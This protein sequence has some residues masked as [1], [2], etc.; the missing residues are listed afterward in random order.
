MM[1]ATAAL[2]AGTVTLVDP[3]QRRRH[4]AARQA[5]GPR[6]TTPTAR[7]WAGCR[8][9][10]A[11]RSR[12]TSSRRRS[13]SGSATTTR[14]SSAMLY[15]TWLKL[16][17]GAPTGIDVAGEV[18]RPRPRPG[19]QAVA[20]DRPRQRRVRAGRGGHPDPARDGVRRDHER[21][22]AHPAARG[23]GHRRRATS[24]PRRRRRS[25]P[26]SCPEQLDLADEPRRRR[27]SVL[28]ATARSC[29]ATRWAARPA[30]P[31]SGI[32]GAGGRGGWKV[33]LFNYSFIGYIARERRV[34]D[35]VVAIRIEEGRPTIARVGQL[36][37]PVLSH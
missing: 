8:S 35:L 24:S 30:R 32:R 17:F 21:R 6:S 28:Q 14:T 29:P 13:R 26:G 15:D 1:T 23:Q 20:P 31:R 16:G 2:E 11:S 37:M 12:A 34:P 3:D 9:R 10:T 22:H 7:A 33:N 27:R 5:A 19:H 18:G 36:E 25:S 4:A